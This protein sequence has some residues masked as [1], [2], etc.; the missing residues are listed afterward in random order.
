[1]RIRPIYHRL[2]NGIKAHVLISFL[3]YAV[4]MEFERRLK[5]K[6]IK[7]K[8]SQKLLKKIIEHIL[9]VEIGNE[10]IPI[11]P[12]AIQRKIFEIFEN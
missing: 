8:F 4:F 5:I 2:E 9:G 10:I 6:G 1:L 7:F 12:S 3:A 11:P